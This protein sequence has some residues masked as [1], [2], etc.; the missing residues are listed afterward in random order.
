MTD[1]AIDSL[2]VRRLTELQFQREIERIAKNYN[3]QIFSILAKA[4]SLLI[5]RMEFKDGK[6]LMTSDL[7]PEVQSLV[8]T[9]VEMRDRELAKF[10]AETAIIERYDDRY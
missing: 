9:W 5:R 6:N 2:P 7:P 10:V 3:E 1:T 4:D 8:D